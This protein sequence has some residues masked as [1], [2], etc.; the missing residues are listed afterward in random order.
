MP[1]PTEVLRAPSFA[2]FWTAS[3]LSSAG[4]SVTSVALPVIVVTLLHASPLEVG[5]VNAAGVAAYTVLGFFAGALIDRWRR[6]PVL[7]WSSAVRAVVLAVIPLLW[8]AHALSIGAIVATLFVFSGA[9]VFGIGARQSFLSS[10]V[11]RSQLVS[12]N[13]RLDQSDAAA[14]T[15]GPALG[16]GLV[17]LLGGPLSIALDALSYVVDAAVLATIRID[18]PRPEAQPTGRVGKEIREGFRWAYS[19]RELGPLAWSTHAW[20][21]ANSAAFTI[22]IPFVLRTLDFTAPIY[23]LLLAATGATTLAGAFAAPRLGRRFGEGAVVVATRLAYPLLWA[24]IT[25]APLAGHFAALPLFAG[26]A[27]YGL[28]M[29]VENANEMGFRQAVTPDELQG[30]TNTTLRSANRTGALVGSLAGGALA[31]I[32]G[33]VVGLWACVA[34]F[35]VAAAIVL[36]SP[37]RSAGTLGTSPHGQ[38]DTRHANDG[39]DDLPS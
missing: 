27:L 10:I 6:K 21:V 1:R 7:V 16:G 31:T 35:I 8:L 13:A 26:M 24:I 3:T 2:R 29:G 17:G 4:T 37:F 28:A 30:R 11:P 38:A 18:E 20:F 25:V 23:G 22:L 32:A 14:S 5:Y 12:A 33:I 15:L 34:I 36:F 9:S 39:D 19:H